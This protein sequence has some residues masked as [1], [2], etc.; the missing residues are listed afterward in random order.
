MDI[1]WLDNDAAHIAPFAEVL[2]DQGYKVQVATTLLGAEKAYREQLPRLV[3]IDVM[4]P[5]VSAEEERIYSPAATGLGYRSGLVFFDRLKGEFSENGT[6]V[7]VFTVRLDQSI[8]QEF[9]DAGLP[10]QCFKTKQ[11]L[12]RAPVFLETVASLLGD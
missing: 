4:V 3:I 8:H 10:E 11:A 7:L 12:R 2:R 5:T 6:A 9:I 1:L